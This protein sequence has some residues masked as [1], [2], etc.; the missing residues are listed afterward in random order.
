MIGSFPIFACLI[1]FRFHCSFRILIFFFVSIIFKIVK[2][3]F[4]TFSFC[5]KRLYFF[6]KFGYIALSARLVRSRW[7]SVGVLGSC[8]V[9]LVTLVCILS[10]WLSVGGCG[11]C[12]VFLLTCFFLLIA[13]YSGAICGILTL[14]SRLGRLSSSGTLTSRLFIL[15]LCIGVSVSCLTG[16]LAVLTSRFFF[17]W[18]IPTNV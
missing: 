9:I 12:S 18:L 3:F 8:R 11:S 2:I 1:H 17:R 14:V 13:S 15:T 10:R 4:Q 16:C 5:F 7:L 6:F